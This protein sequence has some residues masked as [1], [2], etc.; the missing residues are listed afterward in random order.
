M[1]IYTSWYFRVVYLFR[2]LSLTP[3]EQL[4]DGIFLPRGRRT[5]NVTILRC[6]QLEK[7]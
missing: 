4:T 7:F 3:F 2:V 1:P 5:L 6:N